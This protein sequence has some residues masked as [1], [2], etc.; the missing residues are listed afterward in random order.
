[1]AKKELPDLSE[2]MEPKVGLVEYAAQCRG[3]QFLKRKVMDYI[4]D[5]TMVQDIKAVLDLNDVNITT[6]R[7]KRI[8]TNVA[9]TVS[10]L[11]LTSQAMS[12]VDGMIR[13]LRSS[14]H[15]DDCDMENCPIGILLSEDHPIH[16]IERI[17]SSFNTSNE[18][19]P[20]LV[21]YN[22]KAV[23]VSDA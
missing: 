5:G 12:A 3:N 15:R 18:H 10:A 9:F 6:E 20:G 2:L 17:T 22:R 8:V 13:H 7:D 19:V 16:K 14:G 1:M 23:L 21:N 11:A 4:K